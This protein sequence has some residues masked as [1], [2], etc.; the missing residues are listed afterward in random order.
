MYLVTGATGHV[1]GPLVQHLSEAGVPVRAFCR[2]PERGSFPSEVE[3]VAGE[4]GDAG[5]A[6]KALAGVSHLK[7]YGHALDSVV[8]WTLSPGRDGGTHLKLVHDGF[9][10]QNLFAFENMSHGW[11]T[12]GES[13]ERV[14]GEL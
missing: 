12:A 10:Q 3:T 2:H 1:G 8:T 14:L 13:I 5:A 7:D 11:V 6:R 9:R 4:M